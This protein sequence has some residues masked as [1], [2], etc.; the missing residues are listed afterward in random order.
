M[1]DDLMDRQGGLMKRP[2]EPNYEANGRLAKK[3]VEDLKTPATEEE[4]EVMRRALASRKKKGP[5]EDKG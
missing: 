1:M 4:L 5:T 3:L 2:S